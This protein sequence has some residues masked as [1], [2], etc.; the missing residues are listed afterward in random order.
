M[1]EGRFLRRADIELGGSLRADSAR[2]HA[3]AHGHRESLGDVET[4]EFNEREG[5]PDSPGRGSTHRSV[6]RRWRFSSR[7]REPRR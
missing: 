4:E 3:P 6:A 1:S 5:L 7:L 2:W